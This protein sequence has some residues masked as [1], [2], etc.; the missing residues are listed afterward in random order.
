MV[1]ADPISLIYV[2]VSWILTSVIFT[3]VIALLNN[4][5]KKQTT[6]TLLLAIIYIVFFISRFSITMSY[7]LQLLGLK[8]HNATLIFLS[9]ATTTALAAVSFLYIFSC[10][11]LL[12][13]A[14]VTKLVTFFFIVA[15]WAVFLTITVV[16]VLIPG[17][18]W[19][20]RLTD[21]TADLQN[22]SFVP[23]LTVIQ[24]VLQSIIFLRIIIRS[25]II[26]KRTNEITRKRGLQMIGY[27]LL[28]YF[29]GGMMGG[30][31]YA[32]QLQSGALSFSL[33]V[34]RSLIL[35]TA[36]IMMYI[37]WL[38]PDWFRKR[39]RKKTWFEQKLIVD[40]KS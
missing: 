35:L 23:I 39:V 27:G 25:F 16:D 8:E 6:G 12:K 14:E 36:Y 40:S 33:W 18:L 34:F 31:F 21:F 20:T 5:R 13:D 4:F 10:R 19:A 22:I 7:Q 26:A 32:L 24:V 11:H 2:I 30:I 1:I 38:L 28:V 37:G 9:I 15:V 29:L 17:F 3:L